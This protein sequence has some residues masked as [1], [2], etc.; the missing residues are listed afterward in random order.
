MA[1]TLIRNVSGNPISLP[2]PYN[3]VL[4]N[5][6]QVIVALTVDAAIAQFAGTAPNIF[7]FEAIEPEGAVDVTASAAAQ[8]AIA[9]AFATAS[10]DL[11]MN[12]NKITGLAD[13]VSAQDAATKAYVLSQVAGGGVTVIN[14]TGGALAK[15]T[16]VT[17]SAFDTTSGLLTVIAA[18]NTDASK[19]CDAVLAAALADG[20]QVTL[21]PSSD[22]I[23]T[24]S[25]LNTS[26]GGVTIGD[27]VYLGAAGT[28]TLAGPS[29]AGGAAVVQIVGAVKT[30]A[31]SGD[32][33]IYAQAP[34][35]AV[36]LDAATNAIDGYAT[37]AQITALEAAVP[38]TRTV[39]TTAPLAGGGALSGDLTL[40]MAAATN[41]IDGYATSAQ[42]T[43][44]EAATLAL[45]KFKS[46]SG[47]IVAGQTSVV[48]ALGAATWDTLG[49]E[50]TLTSIA[51]GTGAIA[52]A[53]AM[54]SAVVAGSNLTVSLID[55]A[56]ASAATALSDL[57]FRYGLNA[58]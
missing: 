18:S 45:T 13:P 40:S 35:A 6:Q 46:G 4:Q 12:A 37:A 30:K 44:Q 51:N 20:G 5:G 38:N 39:S 43:A 53:P 48:I 32:L 27:P 24:A 28:L 17:I 52:A 7:Y 50:V 19:P 1:K 31:A 56:A 2:L 25:G 11:P 29:F 47:T 10:V 8:P 33:Y 34:I 41:A 23:V 16:P 57:T 3:G 9:E 58:N 55:A 54:F 15:G 14:K 49:A 22:Y 36:T 21:T 42:V 26:G